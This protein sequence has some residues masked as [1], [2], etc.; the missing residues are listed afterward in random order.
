MHSLGVI[1]TA[2]GTGKTTAI[3]ALVG[4]A[5]TRGRRL[6]I[7]SVGPNSQA[8][9]GVEIREGTLA[10]T[11]SACVEAAASHGDVVESLGIPSPQGE[12]LLW[13]AS[14]PCAIP[15]L[16]PARC[17]E[18]TRVLRALNGHVDMALIEG[19]VER[20]LPMMLCD[21][22]MIVTGAARQPEPENLAAETY[23][24]VELLSLPG[25]PDPRTECFPEGISL[26]TLHGELT[27]AADVPLSV[28]GAEAVHASLAEDVTQIL[29]PGPLGLESL[30]TLVALILQTPHRPRLTVEGGTVL[31]LAGR[32]ETTLVSVTDY[33]RAGGQFTAAHS[34][35]VGVVTVN[36]HFME[37]VG[38]RSEPCVVDPR[39][40]RR[41]VANSVPRPVID[42]VR[43][44]SETL[45]EAVEAA[46]V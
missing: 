17:G 6:A 39:H 12:L 35:G 1:S 4:E 16:G 28:E 42:V 32:P 5:A 7:S 34:T 11:A 20:L 44:G 10:V 27:V 36:P 26:R 38:S 23:A 9:E 46:L 2:A 25:D 19:S 14:A 31:L 21:T 40:L 3:D 24:L 33:L 8:S 13:C 43:D 37:R 41:A 45:W 15:L 30:A 22:L 18:F 29:L